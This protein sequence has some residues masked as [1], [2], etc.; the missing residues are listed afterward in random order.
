MDRRERD[1]LDRHITGNYGEDQFAGLEEEFCDA[2][3]Y[4]RDDETTIGDPYAERDAA[5]KEC[6]DCQL[7]RGV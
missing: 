7:I 6:L 1:A 2:H 4:V 3:A 5:A